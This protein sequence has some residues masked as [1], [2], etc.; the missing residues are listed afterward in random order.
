LA[1]TFTAAFRGIA[2]ALDR[3]QSLDADGRLDCLRAELV[4]EHRRLQ[5]PPTADDRVQH[6]GERA[7]SL[8]KVLTLGTSVAAV[9]AGIL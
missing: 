3:C 2:D 4:E 1:A 9:I 7:E 5:P 6:A 8:Q